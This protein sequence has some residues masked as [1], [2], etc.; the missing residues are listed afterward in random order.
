MLADSQV[1]EARPLRI[2]HFLSIL[3]M[4]LGTRAAQKQPQKHL[5]YTAIHDP[6]F[7]PASSATFLHD[8]DRV[9]G[10]VNGRAAK[11]YPAAILSQHGLVED[12]SPSGPIAITW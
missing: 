10:I 9:I 12:Q 2:L 4:I 11:A 7:I 3:S 8:P 6:Q 5:P 1:C